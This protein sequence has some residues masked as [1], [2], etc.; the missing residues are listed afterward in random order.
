[1]PRPNIR[2]R[3]AIDAMAQQLSISMGVLLATE[4]LQVSAW[5]R[6]GDASQ[7]VSGDFSTALFAVSG[8]VLASII[9]FLRMPRDA[10]ENLRK[11]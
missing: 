9:F 5:S 7:L 8:I 3:Q 6:G 11:G 10:G 2:W 1:M 4:L